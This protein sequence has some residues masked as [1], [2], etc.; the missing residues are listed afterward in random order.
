MHHPS[1]NPACLLVPNSSRLHL[2]DPQDVNNVP[3]NGGMLS[4]CTTACA[5]P[6]V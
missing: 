1:I 4:P 2:E 5:S 3:L 6:F